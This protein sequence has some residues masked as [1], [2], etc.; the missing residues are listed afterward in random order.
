[1]NTE[2]IPIENPQLQELFKPGGLEKILV[3]IEVEA[4][5]HVPDIRTKKSRDAIASIAAKVA[6]SKTYLDGL[7][8]DYVTVLKDLPK[9]VDA[10]RKRMRDRMDAVKDEVRKPL[11]DWEAKEAENELCTN[12][13]LEKLSA[14]VVMGEKSSA[15][16]LRLNEIIG[17]QIPGNLNNSQAEMVQQAKEEAVQ[18]IELA[19]RTAVIGERLAEEHAKLKIEAEERKRLDEEEA[20]KRETAEREERIRQEAAEKAKLE[21]ERQI[22]TQR[23][24]D[25]QAKKDAEER[26]I[27]AERA[28]IEAVRRQKD[29]EKAAIEAE[30]RRQREAVEAEERRKRAA[31]EAEDRQR[32]A[33]AE[34]EKKEREK[35]EAERMRK[36]NED[37]K[38]AEDRSHQGEINRMAASALIET[39]G[40]TPAQAI[41]VL[42]AII[43][44]QIPAVS[45]NY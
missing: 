43:K 18:R 12:K 32:I 13:L 8:K 1:M 14:P 38:R 19:L 23:L 16:E 11:T 39:T 33:I 2:L 6:R 17:M 22:E 15:I 40:L 45:I 28:A 21:A 4:R 35:I 36:E 5:S 29:A 31:I 7:G 25:V 3:A 26:Q 37:R 24:R 44:G 30:E 10:E 20:K 41:A 42:T 9:Q 34:A 27:Y